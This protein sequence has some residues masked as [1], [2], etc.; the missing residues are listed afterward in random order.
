MTTLE[1]VAR[2]FRREYPR[3]ESLAQLELKLEEASPPQAIPHPDGFKLSSEDGADLILLKPHTITTSRLAPYTSWESLIG[4]AKEN[5]QVWKRVVE[6]R[7]IARVGVR[8][9]NRIDIPLKDAP[10]KLR[11]ED[12]LRISV[13]LPHRDMV[14]T[15]YALQIQLPLDDGLSLVVNSATVPPP[16]IDHYSFLLDLDFS[17]EGDLPQRDDALWELVDT[18]RKPKNEMFEQFITDKTRA[19]FA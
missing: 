12:Y 6:Y 18:L 11:T 14:Y 15:R 19:L 10:D 3:K 1:K 9:I 4:R 5:W 16:L 17:K 2:K 7:E 8:I 13:E